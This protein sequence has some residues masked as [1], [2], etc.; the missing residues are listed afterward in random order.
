MNSTEFANLFKPEDESCDRA[1]ENDRCREDC[2]RERN[3][4][5][6]E[7]IGSTSI[8][9]CCKDCHNHRFSAVS[10]EAIRSGKSHIHNIKFRTDSY[11]GHYHEFEGKSGP[12]IPV[13]DGR[14]VHFAKAY[15]SNKDGHRHEFKVVSLIENPIGD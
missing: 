8:A 12:A 5:V 11:D 14:H 10:G 4:H 1:T 3:Q 9:E 15:T 7:I 6:H 2:D 13:G